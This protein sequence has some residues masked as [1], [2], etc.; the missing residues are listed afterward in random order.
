LSAASSGSQPLPVP[1]LSALDQLVVAL[2]PDPGVPL[3]Q[4]G[5]RRPEVASRCPQPSHHDVVTDDEPTPPTVRDRTGSHR[6][7]RIV[8]TPP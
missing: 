7:L 8:I 4:A 5:D 3:P 1:E 2:V 6:P